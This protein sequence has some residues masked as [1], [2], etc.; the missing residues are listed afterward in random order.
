MITGLD[1]ALA[2]DRIVDAIAA[3][4]EGGQRAQAPGALRRARGWL[5]ANSRRL[6]K[7]V[8][9]RIPGDKNTYGYQ[10]QRYPGISLDEAKERVKRFGRLL[11]RFEALQV[12]QFADHIFR[13]QRAPGGAPQS[14][15]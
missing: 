3:L 15:A 6:E 11:G 8:R 9:A 10:E 1:G 7:C 2:A 4:E 5:D 12:T 14:Q 13:I